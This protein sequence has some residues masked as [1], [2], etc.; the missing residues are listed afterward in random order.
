MYKQALGVKEKVLGNHHPSILSIVGNIT[1]VIQC[2]NK[3]EE[4]EELNRLA[5]E[6]KEKVFRKKHPSTLSL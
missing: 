6:R 4:V 5:L 1:A 2:R 3:Y